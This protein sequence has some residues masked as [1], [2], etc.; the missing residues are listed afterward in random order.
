MATSARTTAAR[1]APA[2]KAPGARAAA[3][4][5]PARVVTPAA[6]PAKPRKAATP[7][8]AAEAS[9]VAKPA[10]PKEPKPRKPKLVR[11]SFSMPKTE[12][13]VLQALK[14]RAAKAGRP[15]RKSE[16]L[17]AGIQ[18]LAGMQDAA[19]LGAMGAVPTLKTGRPA[20]A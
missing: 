12:Y 20:K 6:A 11:D 13:A 10:R 5:A 17:R 15:A 4:G 18:V 16:L 19:F 3:G 8:K 7:P 14:D 1:K 2:R 9:K